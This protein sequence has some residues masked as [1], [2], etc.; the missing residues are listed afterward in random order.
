MAPWVLN[1]LEGQ[2]KSDITPIAISES[3][4]FLL[5]R[6]CMVVHRTVEGNREAEEI[7]E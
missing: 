4:N 7:L 6:M 1:K 2:F 3:A 5:G